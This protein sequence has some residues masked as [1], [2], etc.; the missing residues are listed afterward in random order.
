MIDS[1]SADETERLLRGFEAGHPLLVITAVVQ[2]C[3]TDLNGAPSG[4]VP[5]VLERLAHQR[6]SDLQPA[7]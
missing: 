6:Q 5:E 2:Q 1:S 7:H 4:E 3:R